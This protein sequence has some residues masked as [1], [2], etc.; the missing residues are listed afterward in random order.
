[1]FDKKKIL[2]YFIYGGQVV[3]MF[4]PCRICC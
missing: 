3:I 2:L 1:M 4:W